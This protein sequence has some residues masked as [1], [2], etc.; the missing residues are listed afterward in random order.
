MLYDEEICGIVW[1]VDLM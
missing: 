1:L